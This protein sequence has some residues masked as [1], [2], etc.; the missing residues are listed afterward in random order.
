MKT[1]LSNISDQEAAEKGLD[2]D[3]D[4]YLDIDKNIKVYIPEIIINKK[5]LYERYIL[6]PLFEGNN[7]RR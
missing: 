3:G 1:M 5:I 4:T 7:E 6:G 2:F